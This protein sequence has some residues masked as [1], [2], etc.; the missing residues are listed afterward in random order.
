MHFVCVSN[1]SPWTY[2]N[3]RP[4]VTNPGCSFESGLGVFAL[5][6][7]KVL[8]T[9]DLVRQI[10]R[11]SRS[12]TPN[13]SSATTTWPACGSPAPSAPIASQFDG[14]YLGLRESMTFRAVPDALAV[15]APPAK[16]PL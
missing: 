4:M 16:N 10:L 5:N 14:D 3:N 11:K 7:M 8:P 2:S 12:R 1:S 6:G 15:V 13:N 9:L